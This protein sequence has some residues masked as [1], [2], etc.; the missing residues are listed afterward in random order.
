MAALNLNRIRRRLK[1]RVQE[2]F[3]Q[4]ERRIFIRVAEEDLRETVKTLIRLDGF[5]HL[6]TITGVD[7]GPAI[8]LIYHIIYKDAVVSLKVQVPKESPVLPTITDLIPGAVFYEREIQDLLGVKFEG[9]SSSSLFILPDG[10]PDGVHPLRKEWT[11]GRIS[12]K[13]RRLW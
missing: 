2:V 7:I 10:W 3:V 4:R 1:G 13:A 5:N 12:K 9:N 8:E 11:L 6:A